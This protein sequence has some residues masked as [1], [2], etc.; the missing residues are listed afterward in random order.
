MTSFTDEE[1]AAVYKAI[2][3]RR[4]IRRQFEEAI[5][6]PHGCW[7]GPFRFLDRGRTVHSEVC[8]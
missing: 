3:L 2:M 1:R 7:A 5:S 4:D 8:K 6:R